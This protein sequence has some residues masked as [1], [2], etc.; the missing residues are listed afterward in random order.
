MSLGV[1][2]AIILVTVVAA[3]TGIVFAIHYGVIL[4][5]FAAL[6]Q[7]DAQ[8]SMERC[9]RAMERELYH[10]DAFCFDWAAWDD[11]YEYVVAPS[12]DYENANL[13]L[14]TFTDNNL[15]F[16]FILDTQGRVVWGQ[17]YDLA[18]EE[19]IEV[20]GLPSKHWAATHPLLGHQTPEDFIAGV[21]MTAKGTMLV[22]SRP[23]TTSISE[24]PLRG[25]LIMGR[26]V[27]DA[28]VAE[29]AEQTLTTLKMWPIKAGWLPV[30]EEIQ[31]GALSPAEPYAFVK[32]DA[33]LRVYSTF[34][35]ILG[36]P[37]LLVRVDVPRNIM[38]EGRD[39][40]RLAG[41]SVIAVSMLLLLVVLVLL[42]RGVIDPI[43]RLTT[44]VTAV[45]SATA[46]TQIPRSQRRDEIGT[47]EREF[48]RMMRRLHSENAE[49]SQAELALAESEARIRAILDGTPDAIVTCDENGVIESANAATATLFG[50]APEAMPRRNIRRL[51]PG[52]MGAGE[53]GAEGAPMLTPENLCR[54]MPQTFG[55]RSDGSTFP[56]RVSAS[57]VRLDGRHMYTFAVGDITELR[58][59]HER[60]LH[61]EH[62]ATIGEMGAAM[63]HEIRNPLAG[64][65]GAVQVLRDGLAPDDER[66][67]VMNE[68]GEQVQRIDAIVQRLLAFAK[69]WTPAKQMCDLR[70]IAQKACTEAQT[71]ERWREMR[72]EFDG[73]EELAVAADPSFVEQVFWNL[74]ENAV[75]AVNANLEAGATGEIRWSFA[76]SDDGASVTVAD[77]GAGMTPERI[78]N[79]FRPFHTTKTHGTGLGLCICKRIMEAHGGTID[80]SSTLGKG[81]SVHLQFPDGDE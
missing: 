40:V 79:L 45:G 62:L 20:D 54:V 67:E 2:I 34:P 4:P 64:L 25:T 30:E 24:G 31:R 14:D 66:R 22:S 53:D 28:F 76:R 33:M 38:A 77:N 80:V 29:L 44:H 11:T 10:L 1:R 9:L 60:V 21:Y 15:S 48:N 59:M 37:A 72:F 42:R 69:A 13:V 49:R 58:A 75:D 57:E 81:T 43:S 39:A 12:E 19:A 71:Q 73:L 6:E 65:S 7:Q 18:T 27:D 5:S 68:V 52:L 74:L 32:T 56:V 26:L 41:W 50:Y 8:E 47:L 70:A 46:L 63:A 61:A 23:I 16:M 3:T 17:A 78:E 36:E 51:M 55:K 35:G